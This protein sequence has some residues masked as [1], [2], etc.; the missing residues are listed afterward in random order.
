MS[1]MELNINPDEAAVYALGGL[2]EIG[3]NTYGIQYGDEIVI[4]DAGVKFPEDELLGIDYVIPDYTYIQENRDKIKALVITHGHEDH[5]G[6]IH[7][8]LDAVNVP[9]YAGPLAMALIKNKL[10]E[11]NQ[12]KTTELHEI[13]EDTVLT[14]DKLSVEFFRTTHSIPDTY[15]VAVHT[16]VGTIV[17]TGDF[18]FD[19]TPTTNQPPNLQKMARIGSEG[20]LLLMSDSTNA[21]RAEFTK[22][23]RWVG[24]TIDKLFDEINGRIIFATFASNMSRVQMATEA[25]LA[26]GRKIAVFGRSMESAVTNGLALG[27][28]D[29]PEEM[30]IDAHEVNKLPPE[31]VL[32]LCTGSQGEPMAALARIANGT[33]KQIKIQP[34]D[35]VIF[36]SSPIPGNTASVDRVINELE[37][38]GANVIHGKVNNIHASGHGGQEEQKLMLSLIKPKYFM[39][40]HGEYR[41]LKVHE[42][43]AHDIGVPKDNTF[44]LDNGDVLA[45]TEDSARIADHFPAEDTYVDGNGIGDV[46]AAVLRDRKLLS[47]DGLVVV[48]ATIDL[49]NKEITAG[50]D[51]LS[52]GFIYMRESEDLI[53]EG[54]KEIFHTILMAMREP[55]AS[56]HS[57]RNAVVS[58][59]QRFLYD[60]TKRR[61]LILPIFIMV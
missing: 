9:V 6:A 27:Y 29:I 42:G 21:E 59:L 53:N 44:I 48:V 12:L 11:H 35:T 15:G 31:K 37:E 57:I 17:E 19:F 23:E 24:K 52:R 60:K 54:R 50:P 13:D 46:G 51:I 1:N 18:K 33:H 25:A 22:S 43:L 41:M 7:F 38:A 5:I 34:N 49:N 20:V 10:E 45:L 55:N 2:G 32:I 47:E 3:K 26:H 28:L 40:V 4:I 36:S 61:P 16:P 8:F 58:H 14:F 56:E 39:P 30:L